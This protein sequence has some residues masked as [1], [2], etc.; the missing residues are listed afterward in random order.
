[1]ADYSENG[2][3]KGNYRKTIDKP[4]IGEVKINSR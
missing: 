4:I 1:M 3:A 2:M